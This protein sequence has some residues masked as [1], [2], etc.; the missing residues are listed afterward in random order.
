MNVAGRLAGQQ[1]AGFRAAIGARGRCLRRKEVT[2]RGRKRQGEGARS[3]QV[4][5]Q[6][7]LNRAQSRPDWVL[8]AWR[9]GRDS[10]PRKTCAFDG[11]Q[12]HCLKPLGHPSI[13]I[14]ASASRT[15]AD[16]AQ[17]S[18]PLSATVLVLQGIDDQQAYVFKTS[19]LNHPASFPQPHA[20]VPAVLWDEL[21][22]GG[23]EGF[24]DAMQRRRT[25]QTLSCFKPPDCRWRNFR[26]ER[27]TFQGPAKQ[28][29]RFLALCRRQTQ[30]QFP[31]IT[32]GVLIHLSWQRQS[33]Q[34]AEPDCMRVISFLLNAVRR[35]QKGEKL[36]DRHE[37]CQFLLENISRH[38]S[39]TAD[40]A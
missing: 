26:F 8:R 28:S 14:C 23:F 37:D 7:Y 34:P 13:V 30:W 1:G 15:G 35:S 25:R 40:A 5:D 19:A 36:D 20:D 12:D 16:L 22:A 38:R 11:F 29:P 17:I 31:Q 24:F 21:D 27:Q 33:N 6:L 3:A 2:P 39:D 32:N 9:K 10:N 18:S 4:H